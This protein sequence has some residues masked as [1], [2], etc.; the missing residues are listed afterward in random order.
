MS[1]EASRPTRAAPPPHA[2]LGGRR[3]R[4][5][6]ALARHLL[7]PLAQPLLH[8]SLWRV[9]ALGLAML[10]GH[11]LFYLLWGHGPLQQ[12]WESLPLRLLMAALGLAMLVIPGL[13]ATV[14]RPAAA[15]AL[16]VI[17]WVTLP[18]FFAW[19]YFCN[20][21]NAVWLASLGATLLIYHHLTDWRLATLGTIAGLLAAWGMARAAGFPS[22]P[23]PAQLAGSN[24]VVLAFCWLMGLVL[25]CPP[26]TSGASSSNT[27]WAPWASWRT[28][29]ARRWSRC[30]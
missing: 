27:R 8:P 12:P 14:P 11:P 20:G 18:W 15:G 4:L 28:S 10:V 30:S 13:S 1:E 23:M 21:G 19:M 24:A 22:E 26:R 6:D 17:L 7:Q 16:S 29:C 5:G 2:A 9:R 3:R 25:G